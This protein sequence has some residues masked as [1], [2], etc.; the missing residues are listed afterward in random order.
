[1][2]TETSQAISPPSQRIRELSNLRYGDNHN[3]YNIFNRG[4]RN[5]Y[6]ATINSVDGYNFVDSARKSKRYFRFEKHTINQSE[7]FANQATEN[8]ANQKMSQ[9]SSVG[10]INSYLRHQSRRNRKNPSEVNQIN[11]YY[12][13][14]HQRAR[15]QVL[16]TSLNL[17]SKDKINEQDDSLKQMAS[18]NTH[19]NMANHSHNLSPDITNFMLQTEKRPKNSRRKQYLK[20]NAP[21]EK[22]NLIPK[23]N[24]A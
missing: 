16:C 7:N 13:R 3:N 15:K 8:D 4:R 24:I 12:N 17:T 21:V 2:H 10:S 18:P 23:F 6:K 14:K 22:V 9:Q 19:R 11:P 20:R 1:M 5:H